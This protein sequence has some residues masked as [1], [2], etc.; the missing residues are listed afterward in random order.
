[1]TCVRCGRT[2]A[3]LDERCP[4]CGA[5]RG[6]AP[7]DAATSISADPAGTEGGEWPM[8]GRDFGSRYRIIELL[9]AAAWAPFTMR[10]T[11]PRR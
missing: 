11:R 6:A 8:A 1:M 4:E 5:V 10:G 9:G 7:P 2:F 3:D